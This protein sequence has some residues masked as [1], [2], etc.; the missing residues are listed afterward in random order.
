MLAAGDDAVES[1]P[2]FAGD[3]GEAGESEVGD[4]PLPEDDPADGPLPRL[5]VR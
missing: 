4:E 2:A 3:P 1:P 5:S